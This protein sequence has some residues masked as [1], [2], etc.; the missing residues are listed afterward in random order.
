LDGVASAGLVR[1]REATPLELVEA[2]IAR[3]EGLNP[4]LNA[5][6]TPLAERALE[7]AAGVD[8]RAPLAGVPCVVK[9]LT[10]TVGGVRHSEGSRLLFDYVAPADSAYVSRLR[11]AG[12]V[13]VGIANTAE[14][15]GSYTT[16]P[17]AFGPTLNPF[18]RSL[19]AGGSSGGSAA[20][21]AAGIVPV[22]H[23]NDSAGSL[24]AP[25]SCCGL[26]G[27]KP[28]RG[29]ISQG[30]DHGDILGGLQ[31]EHVL[32]R[33]V[34]DSA[35]VLDATAGPCPGDP[36]SPSPPGGPFSDEVGRNPGRL[37]I[38][39]TLS[40]PPGLGLHDDCA[41]AV[42]GAARLCEELGHHVEPAAPAWH[43]EEAG[44]AA[45]NV[46]ADGMAWLAAYW[47]GRVGRPVTPADVEPTTWHLIELGR[48]RSAADH[49]L[50]RQVLQRHARRVSEFFERY[51][52]WLTSTLTEVPPPVGSLPAIA[53]LA[54]RAAREE[55]LAAFLPAANIT[56]QPAM[57][58]PLHWTREGIPIGVQFVARYGAEATLFRLAGQI[59]GARP[60]SHR[61]P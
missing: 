13:L 51:D 58:V 31:V 2:A 21:V 61:R 1:R 3:M 45:A 52:L 53:E 8:A 50:D 35:A 20:A 40:A 32:T 5:I 37:H 47:G 56:G 33:T 57:S 12:M 16:E 38:G 15:G 29:R 27:L 49:L 25:A 10:V 23:G 17:I 22:G 7:A 48:R 26:F 4:G 43:D 30:P 6:V 42:E 11:A 60:W 41:H 34:R 46:W 54:E 9:D 28:T 55:R 24:R 44:L 36:Y 18:D 19:S 14:F 59:D 39:V